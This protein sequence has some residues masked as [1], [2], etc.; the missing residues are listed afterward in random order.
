VLK[1]RLLPY[2]D[3]MVVKTLPRFF[4]VL[5]AVVILLMNL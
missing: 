1:L 2:N 3:I 4:R 5:N